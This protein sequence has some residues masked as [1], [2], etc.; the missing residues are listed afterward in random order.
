MGKEYK[1]QELAKK[2][3]TRSFSRSTKKFHK[4]K[5]K[6]K[7]LVFNWINIEGWNKKKN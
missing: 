6:K 4:K 1:F 5:A 3:L 7:N 2:N